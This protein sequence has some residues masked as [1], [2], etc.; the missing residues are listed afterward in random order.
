M[1][2]LTVL[3]ILRSWARGISYVKKRN[4]TGK[5]PGK[6]KYVVTANS[7]MGVKA[8]R[9]VPDGLKKFSQATNVLRTGYENTRKN[10]IQYFDRALDEYADVMEDLL[11]QNKQDRFLLEEE[12]AFL[13][14]SVS[15][16]S[17]ARTDELRLERYAEL[18]ILGL[19]AILARVT[20]VAEQFKEDVLEEEFDGTGRRERYLVVMSNLRYEIEQLS[21]EYEEI[22]ITEIGRS[23]RRVMLRRS[24]HLLDVLQ[25]LY[26][27]LTSG[28]FGKIDELYDESFRIYDVDSIQLELESKPLK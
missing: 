5:Y 24:K 1:C 23:R 14:R 6:F 12:V 7:A 28:D 20:D 9:A 27:S 11:E 13:E 16:F 15:V 8:H 25:T 17:E 2:G 21:D 18:H 4:L 26:F 19:Q 22:D 3:R 10:R